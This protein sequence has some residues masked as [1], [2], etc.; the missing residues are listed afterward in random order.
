[1]LRYI[2]HKFLSMFIAMFVIITMT[3]F[4]M[5]AI[6]G[7]PFTEEKAIPREILDALHHHYGLDKPLHVQYIQYLKS[8][9][10]CDLGPSFKYKGHSVDEIIRSGFPISM[11]LGLEALFF[12][13]SFGIFFGTIAALKQLH[14]QDHAAMLV[15]VIGISIPSFI[16]ASFLQYCFSLKLGVL[17]IARWE[18]FLHTVLPAISLGMLPT[19]FI[20][21]LTRSSMLEILQQD[22]IKTAKAKGL[23]QTSV[24]IRHALRNALL[25]VVSYLGPLTANILTGSFVVEKI[26]GIPGLGQWFVISIQNRDYTIIMGTTIFYSAILLFCVFFV[27]ILYSIIDP[28]IR[29]D[30]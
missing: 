22:Y 20:A 16:L 28:R 5:K 30:A 17:P 25:P 12:S 10:Q 14:W 7:D 21:R 9:T 1:M 8:I 26:F 24:I 4:M 29:G 15:A 23:S 27:D 3:F 6:P 19:S 18:S 11:I 13:L 2:T